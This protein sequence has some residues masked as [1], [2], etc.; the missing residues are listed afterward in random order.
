MSYSAQ[1]TQESGAQF[2]SDAG[3]I[4]AAVELEGRIIGQMAK[5]AAVGTVVFVGF[6]ILA[7]LSAYSSEFSP[8]L[9]TSLDSSTAMGAMAVLLTSSTLLATIAFSLAAR[10]RD[11]RDQEL[12]YLATPVSSAAIFIGLITPPI[13][14]ATIFSST[15]HGINIPITALCLVSAGFICLM[16]S[17][18]TEL[19]YLGP[20]HYRARATFASKAK[21]EQR[22]QAA[23]Q[24]LPAF[25]TPTRATPGFTMSLLAG[26]CVTAGASIWFA[27]LLFGS[28]PWHSTLGLGALTTITLALSLSATYFGQVELRRGSLVNS[29][30][31]FLTAGVWFISLTLASLDSQSPRLQVAVGC[32]GVFSAI[33]PL[34][35]FSEPAARVRW[36]SAISLR[37][38]VATRLHR[39]AERMTNQPHNNSESQSSHLL[40]WYQRITGTQQHD[41]TAS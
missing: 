2:A 6:S 4:R 3:W 27:G 1:P 36:L 32:I 21:E 29:F 40:S 18:T 23:Q 14:L 38:A 26:M 11:N 20:E 13:S 24:V 28:S 41:H 12:A 8:Y 31:I 37:R 25:S 19:L 10:I 22:R 16:C 34:I 7:T 33:V 9:I 5:F 30:L 35:L 39:D 17:L 15:P